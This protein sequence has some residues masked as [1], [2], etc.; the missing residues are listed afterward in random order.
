MSNIPMIERY[1]KFLGLS[2]EQMAKK[3]NISAS[4]YQ[5]KIHGQSPWLLKEAYQAAEIIGKSMEEIFF[6]Q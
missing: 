3:M 1:R 4:S 6:T 5:K 2:Q